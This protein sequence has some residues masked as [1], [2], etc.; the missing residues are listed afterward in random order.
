MITKPNATA[1]NQRAV[2]LKH[3]QIHG[4]LTTLYARE[5]LGIMS[6]AVRI[7][8]LRKRDFPIVTHWTATEDKAGT[9]HREAKYVLFNDTKKEAPSSEQTERDLDNAN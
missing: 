2:I 9:R 3:L 7:L 8:E 4:S 6:P 5:K 1:S